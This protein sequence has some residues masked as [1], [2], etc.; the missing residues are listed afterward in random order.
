MIELFVKVWNFLRCLTF[1]H[2]L[3]PDYYDDY[4]DEEWIFDFNRYSTDS[5]GVLPSVM[6][7]DLTI[8]MKD[9]GILLVKDYFFISKE[10]CR[11]EYNLNLKDFYNYSFVPNDAELLKLYREIRES[12]I[13]FFA[14]EKRILL[15]VDD[16][17]QGRININSNI[18]NLR[19]EIYTDNFYKEDMKR[20]NFCREAIRNFFREKTSSHLVNLEV[21][22]DKSLL[23][24]NMYFSIYTTRGVHFNKEDFKAKK[25]KFQI[26]PGNYT[27]YVNIASCK[28]M[29]YLDDHY[30]YKKH[31]KKFEFDLVISAEKN[32]QITFFWNNNQVCIE[33]AD[34]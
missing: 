16:F 18:N 10:I 11:W 34:L 12:G 13:E 28:K 26:L 21:Y 20:L 22:V 33:E 24:T 8:T 30:L 5:D 4:I 6:P 29:L 3:F 15:L 25:N 14:G 19:L 31:V 9:N 23:K 27:L 7:D 1:R 32:K 17:A 2:R